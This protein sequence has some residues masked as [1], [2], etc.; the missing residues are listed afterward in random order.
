MTGYAS[1][2]KQIQRRARAAKRFPGTVRRWRTDRC[3]ACGHRFRWKRDGRHGYGHSDEVFHDACM[4]ARHWRRVAGERLDVLDVVSDLWEIKSET[5]TE[6]MAMRYP[7]RVS[8][9]GW[10][11]AWRVF[12]DL[13]KHRKATAA[14]E[15]AGVQR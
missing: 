3:A 13:D 7:E 11:L 4:S 9:N 5:V 12:Y 15:S 1:L 6:I 8:H 14:S 2:R 10:N